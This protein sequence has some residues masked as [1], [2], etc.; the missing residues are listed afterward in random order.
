[1]NY[2][3]LKRKLKF[4]QAICISISIT[5]ALIIYFAFKI[6]DGYWI[7]MTVSIVFAL[8]TQG[9]IERRGVDRILGTFFGLFLGFFYLNLFMYY[10]YCWV[11]FLPLVWFAFFYIQYTTN[12]YC[13]TVIVITMF[14]PIVFSV[15]AIESFQLY[16]TLISRFFCTM[17]GCFI[18]LI[19]ERIIYRHAARQTVDFR[20]YFESIFINISYTL[21][22]VC[23]LFLNNSI[24]RSDAIIDL[25]TT[26]D[27][28]LSIEKIYYDIK[29]ELDY[30]KSHEEF[31]KLLFNNLYKINH[32]LLKLLALLNRKKLIIEDKEL[33]SFQESVSILS[34]YL[35]EIPK[36]TFENVSCFKKVYLKL[37]K[38]IS[39]EITPLS[40]LSE[41]LCNISEITDDTSLAVSQFRNK[42]SVFGIQ[43]N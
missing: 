40:I 21:D 38:N 30:D 37:G 18:A 9:D 34:Y 14:I 22:S 20:Y 39:E 29:D 33:I 15:L 43:V 31:Y 10:D 4:Q 41:I 23:T 6:Q 11:Y 26:M 24:K 5:V 19:A 25:R 7:P 32:E 8:P 28:F 42:D 12:N 27:S 36:L 3:S 13:M 35:E 16:S 1:M 17:I 2:I